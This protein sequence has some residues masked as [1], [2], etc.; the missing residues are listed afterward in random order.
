MIEVKSNEDTY[1][2]YPY[3]P[4]VENIVDV[5]VAKTQNYSRDFFRLQ[6]NFYLSLIPSALNIKINSKITGTIPINF[7]GVNLSYSGS[8]KGF[9]TVFLENE[10]LGLFKDTFIN[11]VYKDKVDVSLEKESLIR[12]H[13]NNS[14][15]QDELE[16]LEKEFNSYGSYKFSFD[17]ATTPAIKQY[18]NKIMLAKIG[19]INLIIDEVGSNLKSNLEPLYTFLELY[20]KGLL[21]DKLIKNT[22]EQQRYKELYGSTPANLLLFGTPTKVFDGGDIE[23]NFFELLEIGYARRCFFSLSNKDIRL[24]EYSIEELYDLMANQE[25]QKLVEK[26]ATKLNVLANINLVGIT[27]NVDKEIEIKLLKYRS[28]CEK[29]SQQLP[30]HQE[31]LKNELS[32][33]YFKTLKLAGVYALISGSAKIEEEHLKQ[34]IR[35]AEDSGKALVNMLNRPKPYE[36]LAK[37]IADGKGKKF[38]QVDLMEEL[39]YFKGSVAQK[40]DLM[41]MAI[42]WGYGNNIIIKKHNQEGIDFYSGDSLE[43]T[44]LEKLKISYSQYFGDG[45]INA[46]VNFHKDFDTLIKQENYNWTN[47]FL[48]EGKRDKDHIIEG[49]NCV[50]LD[51]DKETTINQAKEILKDYSYIIHTTKRHLVL[52]E[53]TGECNDRFRIILPINYELNLTEP[54]YKQFMFNIEKLFP[55]CL[56]SQTFQRNRK[57]SCNPNAVIFKNEGKLLNILPLVP[58]TSK[59]QEFQKMQ[60]KLNSLDA[61]DRWFIHKIEFEKEPRNNTLLRYAFMLADSGMQVKEIEN[62]VLNLNKSL[63]N[64][65]DSGEIEKTI[66]VSL[67]KRYGV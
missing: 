23:D 48:K 47:H 1:L 36:R 63:K 66:F 62:R 61:I 14:D 33:R 3:N 45:Y 24:T 35:F 12:S 29:L 25:K 43:E 9:S 50:V 32:H 64:P 42:A 21:K 60:E 8:G 10:L 52:D 51:I 39:P 19:S 34:A 67:N 44:N 20:D 27:L 22:S 56:D 40:Q 58:K 6:T 41:N 5:L 55:F 2:E 31:I 4:I 13:K 16:K 18:R 7:Y 37:F 15:S 46:L 59:E 11:E 53:E 49:F 65:L 26:L 30:E 17:S 28:D 38:T 54:D 57:W